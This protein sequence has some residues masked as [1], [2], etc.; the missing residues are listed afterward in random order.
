M[1]VITGSAKGC[2][3]IC[4]EGLKTRPTS[5]RVKEALFNILAPNIEGACFLDLFGGSGAIAIEALSRGAEYAV[6]IDKDDRAVKVINTNIDKTRLG[7]KAKVYRTDAVS[8]IARLHAN[9]ELFDIVFLDPPYESELVSAVLDNLLKYSVLKSGAV[10]IVETGAKKEPDIPQ[11]FSVV[12]MR[13]YGNTK[14][15]FL[16]VLNDRYISGQL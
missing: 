7:A 3:L 8:A 6:I 9:G 12:D 5:D 15:V 14:F 10:V 16:E 4:T 2:K 13:K 11:G 1:R